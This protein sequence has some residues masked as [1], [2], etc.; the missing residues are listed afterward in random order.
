M[1]TLLSLIKNCIIIRTLNFRC[2]KTQR[3]YDAC[4]LANLNIERP[5]IS[6]YTE[7]KIVDSKRP[8]PPKE[9]KL[10]FPDATP[11]LPPDAPE[12]VPSHPH[13]SFI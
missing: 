11:S 7:A 2:R 3:V 8:P 1:I 9:P 6:Y 12:P 4:V 5:R 13:R 10:R